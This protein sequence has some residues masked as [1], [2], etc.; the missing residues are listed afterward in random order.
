MSEESESNH[1]NLNIR[2]PA[3]RQRFNVDEALMDKMV[4]CGG[5]DTRF[6]INDEV[7]VRVKKFYP[8][9]RGGP[10]LNRF[11]R[12]PLSAAVPEG[13]Q[14]M[15]YAEFNHPER[16]GPAS[17][18]RVIAGA[19][20]V[21]LMVLVALLLIFAVDT[22]AAFSGVTLTGRLVIAG[23]SAI[24]G[25]VL[26]V[27][28][29]PKARAKAGLVAALLGA[30]VVAIPFFFTGAPIMDQERTPSTARITEPLF[31]EETVGPL[32]ELRQRF[33]TT[34]LEEERERLA[35]AGS[36]NSAFGVYLS[37]IAPRNMYTA[38]DFLIRDTEAGPSS[39]RYPRDDGDALI[40][41]TNVAKSFDEV[42]E[43]AAG[44]GVLEGKYPEL[45]IVAVRVNN[46]YFLAGAADKL[47]NPK[48]PAFYELNKRELYSIDISRVEAAVGRLAIAEP[49]VYRA[50]I[51]RRLVE[52]LAKPRVRFHGEIA[53]AL[54]K[55]AEQPGPAG[56]AALGVLED[57]HGKGQ[58]V[59]ESVIE[60]LVAEDVKE[61]I[62]TINEIWIQNPTL[63]TQHYAKFGAEVESRVLQQINAES[64]PLRRSALIILAKVGTEKSL[65]AIRKIVNDNNPDVRV[66]AERAI[67]AINAR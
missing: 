36:K 28:A 55:W 27:Y 24:L 35:D 15:R 33:G 43:I 57:L 64:A 16:L 59:P 20:G 66:L 41:L 56:E 49:T 37:Q 42:A 4:E 3:C 44:L 9:E 45:G 30:G 13:M 10:G 34:P 29:N 32:D 21:A 40:L 65:P 1:E 53:R 63:W 6:R 11:Q 25:F 5:C 67:H 54:L 8:G 61:A 46:D 14:T 17:P 19:C 50:D 48:D 38:R 51:S 62:P 12:V 31:P 2:C 60:L 22:G 18:A 26:L 47:K 52:L 7:I 39:H 23:F 58:I